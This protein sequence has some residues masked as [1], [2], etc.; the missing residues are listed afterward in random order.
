M[1]KFI[2][3][4]S[5][6]VLVDGCSSGNSANISVNTVNGICPIGNAPYCMSVQ[7]VNNANG[8]NYINNSNYPI[9]NVTVQVNAPRGNISSPTT[10]ATLDPNNCQNSTIAPGGS[11]TFYL[12]LNQIAGAVSSVATAQVTLNY[13]IN[14][15]MYNNTNTT[16]T[17]TF[18]VYELTSLFLNYNSLNQTNFQLFN[19]AWATSG[20]IANQTTNMSTVYTL[21]RGLIYFGTNQGVTSYDFSS[22]YTNTALGPIGATFIT[23]LI[24]NQNNIFTTIQSEGSD[25]FNFASLSTTP[26]AWLSTSL[27]LPG[28]TSINTSAVSNTGSFFVGVANGNRQPINEVY[29]CIPDNTTSPATYACNEEGVTL[30]GA[31]FV[32]SLLFASN[33]ITDQNLTGLFAGTDNGIYAESGQTFSPNNTWTPVTFIPTPAVPQIINSLIELTG[34]GIEGYYILAGSTSGNFWYINEQQTTPDTITAISISGALSEPIKYMVYDQLGSTSLSSIIV[35]VATDTNLYNCTFDFTL[36]N[37]T[38]TSMLQQAISGISGLNLTSSLNTN[39][40]NPGTLNP[41]VN[42]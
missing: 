19:G 12:R 8:Q 1:K 4:L 23:N 14:N 7:I 16:G 27:S 41:P 21:N 26:F 10:D 42:N 3:I 5:I 31:S 40:N 32:G 15:S 22:N 20:Y 25:L 38:C 9:S 34:S 2:A 30:P 18:S 6:I 11:C 24:N 28:Y 17:Y 39:L 35:Y 29:S 37:V 36:V 33:N 13:N